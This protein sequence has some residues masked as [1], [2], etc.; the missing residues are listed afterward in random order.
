MCVCVC[1]CARARMFSRVNFFA[2]PWTIACQATSCVEFSRQEYWSGKVPFSRGSSQ[3][4]DRTH[5]SHI[6]CI[7]RPILTTS[8][9]WEAMLL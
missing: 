8:A 6:S 3:H 4:R 5:V 7:G 9:T 1:V 2:T